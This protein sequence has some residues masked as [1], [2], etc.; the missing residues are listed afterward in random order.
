MA[1]AAA[2]VVVVVVVVVVELLLLCKAGIVR[3]A[4][5]CSGSEISTTVLIT[6]TTTSARQRSARDSLTICGEIMIR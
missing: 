5:W 1:A 4:V 2:V 3:C 6:L